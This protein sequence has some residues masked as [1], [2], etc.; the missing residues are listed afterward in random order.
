M[1]LL[2]VGS[3]ALMANQIALQ[4]IG[5]NIANV[6]TEGYSRQTVSMGT[7]F[8]QDIGYGYVG[9]GVS[10]SSIVRNYSALLNRQSNTAGSI[11][12]ADLAR[13]A[14]LSRC[15]KLSPAAK[16]AWARR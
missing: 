4:T 7:N 1:S 5:N 8:G 6:K 15:R 13:A 16:A 2:N 12:A 9:N 11:H 10:V 3:G 14:S